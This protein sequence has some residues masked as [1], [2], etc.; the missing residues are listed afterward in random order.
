M[1]T[2]KELAE[3][4]YDEAVDWGGCKSD[5]IANMEIS[6]KEYAKEA[7]KE[8][9]IICSKSFEDWDDELFIVSNK[10]LYSPEPELK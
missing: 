4:Y 9:R 8:Q 5:H 10:V 2:A 7:C 6:M 3:K 1:K